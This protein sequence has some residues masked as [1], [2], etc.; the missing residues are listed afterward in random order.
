MD[1]VLGF[2]VSS[3]L[4]FDELATAG[5]APWTPEQFYMFALTSPEMT[6]YV[7]ITGT[8]IEDKYN[9]LLLHKSQYGF[10]P[11]QLIKAGVNW[12]GEQVAKS[13]GVGLAEGFTAFF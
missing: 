10:L 4:I 12:I 13:T 5:V 8:P 7:D 3:S 6:H 11:P 1:A 2:G 9:A